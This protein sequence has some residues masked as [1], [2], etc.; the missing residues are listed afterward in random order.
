M[1]VFSKEQV[2]LSNAKMR[3]PT[4][5]RMQKRKRERSPSRDRVLAKG[6]PVNTELRVLIK[7]AKQR[8]QKA[9][10]RQKRFAQRM[11]ATRGELSILETKSVKDPQK[12]DYLRRLEEFYDFISHH[13]IDIK[14]EVK[15]DE[16][17]CEYSDHMF[18]NGESN[19]SGQKLKA[20]LE[21]CRPESVRKGELHLPR[22]KRALKGWR[23]MAPTQ[24]RLPMIEFIKGA[25]TGVM[26]YQNHHDMALYNELTFSTYARPGEMLKVLAVDVIQRNQQFHHDVI[27]L[28]PFE[29]GEESKTGVFDEVLILDDVRMPCLGELVVQLAKNRIRQEGEA[30]HLWTFSAKQYLDVWR[31]CVMTLG[32]EE[33]AE[34]PYQN[35]HGGAS[36]DHL[37]R[38][39][40]VAA[41]QRRGRWS[42]DNSARIYDKPGRLQQLIN[43]VS[44]EL[45]PFGENMRM[46]FRNLYLGGKVVL[47]R[48]VK[49]RTRQFFK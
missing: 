32:L 28:A 27:A 44:G 36:R 41:I 19:S 30:A 45:E 25:I 17:L 14:D 31:S 46:H 24:T 18:L 11:R 5:E 38:L 13:E 10:Q 1:A 47:P 26:L 49:E 21:F 39:R 35:R 7:S 48:K 42:S 4:P 6:T 33:I 8:R 15:L 37:L 29:R 23:R 9:R 20:A 3:S 43:K 34:S 16:A 12:R 40:S 2:R 22:F